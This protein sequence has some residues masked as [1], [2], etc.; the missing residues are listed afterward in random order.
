MKKIVLIAIM[1]L[2]SVSVFSQVVSK[3]LPNEGSFTQI[4]F[5]KQAGM[6]T[7]LELSKPNDVDL[8]ILAYRDAQ[9]TQITD[10]KAINLG[11][12]EVANN[13]KNAIADLA[14]DTEGKTI[15]IELPE[16]RGMIIFSK[17]KVMGIAS[18]KGYVTDSNGLKSETPYITLKTLEK[19]FPSSHFQQ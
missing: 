6:G 12:K 19:L 4:G 3:G 8:Y 10:M 14:N 2:F 7:I 11:T 16:G 9:Y 18:M 17:V 13:I 1:A 15:T 5:V